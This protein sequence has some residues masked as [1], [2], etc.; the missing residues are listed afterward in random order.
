MLMQL[1][2]AAHF[3]KKRYVTDSTCLRSKTLTYSL[4]QPFANFGTIATGIDGNESTISFKVEG[5][6]GEQWVSFYY[7]S[8][9]A[10]MKLSFQD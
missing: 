8:E 9:Y 1:L 10:S 5:Q 2:R 3:I 6:G 4:K 7:Q